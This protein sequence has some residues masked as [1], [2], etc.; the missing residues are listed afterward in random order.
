MSESV[1]IT[2]ASGFLGYHLIMAA[3]EK[4]LD[5]FAAVRGNS[6]IEHLKDLPIKFVSLNYEDVGALSKV[7]EDNKIN[8]IVHAA[9]VT[10]AVKQ[11]EYDYVNATYSLNLAKAVNVDRNYFKKMVFISSLAA[12][13]T[14]PPWTI[15]DTVTAMKMML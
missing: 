7:L 1:L 12:V 4:N 9:G 3:L 15:T 13:G 14:S 11:Q 5:V 8:Y 10:K 2:G 6:R